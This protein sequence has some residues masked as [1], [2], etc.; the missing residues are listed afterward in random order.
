M[1]M[2]IIKWKKFPDGTKKSQKI[3]RKL[4]KLQN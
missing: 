3:I 1:S 2:R 4:M